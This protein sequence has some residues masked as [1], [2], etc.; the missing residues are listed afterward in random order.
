MSFLQEVTPLG[1]KHWGKKRSSNIVNQG[2]AFPRCLVQGS[3]KNLEEASKVIGSVPALWGEGLAFQ[4]LCKKE[5]AGLS[6][7][8]KFFFFLFTSPANFG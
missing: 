8:G 5:N 2:A 7:H 6:L 1:L 4:K 3:G